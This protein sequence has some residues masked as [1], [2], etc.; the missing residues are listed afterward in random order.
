MTPIL[1]NLAPRAPATIAVATV[2]SSSTAVV[3][4]VVLT[5]VLVALPL[6]LR[7]ASSGADV[8]GT[9]SVG[10]SRT[11]DGG[12]STGPCHG[13]GRRGPLLIVGLLRQLQRFIV[14]NHGVEVSQRDR[15][16]HDAERSRDRVE[17][18]AQ[19][20]KHVVDDLVISEGRSSR[21]HGVG[22]SLHLV[23]VLAGS[24]V[25]LLQRLNLSPD[26]PNPGT[27]LRAE[28]GVDGGPRGSSG[29]AADQLRRNVLRHGGEEHP[30]DLLV[31]RPPCR[32][33]RI[34]HGGGG[35]TRPLGDGLG[36]GGNGAVEVAMERGT[37]EMRHGEGSP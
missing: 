11:V 2:A 8:G 22:K 15:S 37:G 12:G 18:L 27:V 19:S 6:L 17:G 13:V 36:R 5:A 16:D 3:T 26:V 20:G 31:L 1:A 9:T 23:H 21:G 30:E 4:T 10:C 24:H 32:V 33:R 28:H 35:A 25:V 7:V 34:R 14:E 29:L